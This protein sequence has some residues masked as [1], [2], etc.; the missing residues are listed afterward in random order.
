[1]KI[2]AD[3]RLVSTVVG[4]NS[5]NLSQALAADDESQLKDHHTY[6]PLTD[7]SKDLGDLLDEMKYDPSYED[8]LQYLSVSGSFNVTGSG[9]EAEWNQMK[10]LNALEGLNIDF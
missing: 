9:Y 6:D 1:M 8:L 2:F 5:T 7:F 4:E 10:T 3:N